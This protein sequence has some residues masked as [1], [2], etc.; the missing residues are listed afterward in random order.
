MLQLRL[1]SKV[2]EVFNHKNTDQITQ[3]SYFTYNPSDTPSIVDHDITFRP[4]VGS[5]GSD[6]Y[7]PRSLIYDL[8]TGLGSLKK[9]NALYDAT[10]QSEVR[11]LW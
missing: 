1:F 9:I 2:R 6:T 5:D 7:T 10:D 4:G 8:R 11:G 3:E